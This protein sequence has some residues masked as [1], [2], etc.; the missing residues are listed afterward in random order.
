MSAPI[1]FHL[2]FPVHD[3]EAARAFYSGVLGCREARS[4]EDSIEFDFFGHQ[5]VAHLAPDEAGH[6]AKLHVP[7]DDA[8]PPR[9]FGA[10]FDWEEWPRW[11]TRLRMAG[12]KFLVE[13]VVLDKGPGGDQA[14]VFFADPSGNV[15]E[16]K[17]F[18]DPSRIFAR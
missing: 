1:P 15:L 16:F 13:P 12:V 10:V 6:N 14:T 8:V 4:S 11:V 18:R 17:S 3:L 9:H 5:I 2:A 7:G